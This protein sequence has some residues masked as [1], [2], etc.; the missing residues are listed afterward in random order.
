MDDST[1]AST[2]AEEVVFLEIGSDL[3]R[4]SG[5]PSSFG[6]F[7]AELPRDRRRVEAIWAGNERLVI[8]VTLPAGS[9]EA[10]NGDLQA[11]TTH[12]LVERVVSQQAAP[13][14]L[15]RL[16][17][18]TRFDRLAAISPSRLRGLREKR[19]D[20]RPDL[21]QPHSGEIIVKYLE[22][23]SE[24]PDRLAA[25][26]GR[27]EMLH[28]RL[29]ATVKKLLRFGPGAVDVVALPKGLD[30][31]TALEVYLASEDV[32]Y[33]EPNH[34]VEAVQVPNDPQYPGLWGMAKISAPSAWNTR[35]NASSVIVAITDTGIDYAHPD[36]A[37][38]M[39]HNPGE[40]P[41]NGIDDD[42][43]GIVDDYYGYNA[44]SNHGN[45]MDDN[46]YWRLTGLNPDGSP[47]FTHFETYHGTHVAGT[48]GAVG[49]NGVGVTGVAWSTQL[50]AV[51]VLGSAGTGQ[52]A[53]IVE[54]LDYARLEG[55][56][57]VNASWGGG[58]FSQ[59]I[60]DAIQRLHDA[61]I[62]FVS[63]AGNG[64]NDNDVTP[65]HPGNY[66]LPT[67]VVVGA[68]DSSDARSIWTLPNGASNWGRWSVDVFAPGTGILSTQKS[69]RYRTLNGTSMAAPHVA[70]MLALAKAQF[71]WESATELA[72]RARFSV[73]TIGGLGA[74]SM[75]GGRINAAASL[76]SN[77]PRVA[78]QSV[79][80]QI[81]TGQQIAVNGFVIRGPNSKRVAI[82]ALGPIL[83]SFGISGALPDTQIVIR[84]AAGQVIGSNDNWGTL[85][86]A[87]RS[88][89]SSLGMA[90][91]HALESAWIATLA[92]G[93]YTVELSGVG[94]GT[95]IGLLE[96][97]D[98]DG[99]S[100]SRLVNASSRCFIGTGNSIAIGG[101]T[102]SGSK[103]R[104][105]YIRVLG[106][107]LSGFGINSALSDPVVSL[108]NSSNA[109]V[110]TNDNWR[111]FDG[112]STALETRLSSTGYGPIDDRD[113]T[114]V[115]RLNPGAYTLHVSGKNGAT[116]VALIE[117][118]EY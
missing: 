54:G 117:F 79:R 74:V 35:T 55:A 46:E 78:N 84:N 33:A 71:P 41:G 22:A 91:F 25:T 86:Q 113:S 5:F 116:G 10:R 52:A 50:M 13:R 62:L 18:T 39:W 48:I 106:P 90:P 53:D 63:A 60:L 107:S 59:S 38:N 94:G 44:V 36:L 2:V 72:D 23:E 102:V 88:E 32:E 112:A 45:P 92:P 95:G 11:L 3:R 89:L 20:F 110:A 105:V 56:H 24:T 108:Y 43:N 76:V 61:G 73:D 47:I 21:T 101:L 65:T 80:A 75:A 51:K 81:N 37:G 42:G 68:S 7:R 28:A 4:Q 77:R 58:G 9:I 66:G 1:N 70:G 6:A 16:D 30:M 96:T 31:A 83:T 115:I 97:L 118:N 99:S 103:P 57:I 109:V 85:S 100:V 114:I 26:R 14:L 34:V 64:N 69:S 87:N 27:V 40:I 19:R 8:E 29:G 17:M 12:P 93:L 49:N 15:G 67:T 98:V 104:Q 82:R 111:D